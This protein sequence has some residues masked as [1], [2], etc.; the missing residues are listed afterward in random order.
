MLV[1]KCITDKLLHRIGCNDVVKDVC[2]QWHGVFLRCTLSFRYL[3]QYRKRV[4]TF[5]R[6]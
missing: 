1:Y 6:Y 4:G 5:E 2:K 3:P